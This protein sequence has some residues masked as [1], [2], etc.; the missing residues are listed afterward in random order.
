[1]SI[2][3]R[4]QRAYAK[5]STPVC[6]PVA[7][8]DPSKKSTLFKMDTGFR[9]YDRLASRR[10][11][12]QAGLVAPKSGEGGFTLVELSI[13]IV[14][15]GLIV[16]GVVAGSNMIQSARLKSVIAEFKSYQTAVNMF[17]D[18]YDY[19]PGDLP[20]A[21]SYWPNAGCTNVGFDT[22]ACLNG[23]NGN[24]NGLIQQPS[25]FGEGLRAWQ[26]LALA[27]LIPGT[28]TGSQGSP[29]G[30]YLGINNPESKM[31][32]SGW[33]FRD[34]TV[35]NPSRPASYLELS[36]LTA[37]TLMGA[38]FTPADAMSID[39]KIDDGKPSDGKV[40]GGNTTETCISGTE[41]NLASSKVACL[42]RFYLD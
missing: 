31:K 9:Q 20:T 41:Y 37:G 29:A 8:R 38:T 12:S 3:L 18:K 33:W 14:I 5:Q 15:I 39:S 34:Y 42:M 23:C 21:Y 16:G 19:L 2:I 6:H 4:H 1:L 11:S 13:V 40:L 36:K 28:Y 35:A 26:H 24:G 30:H 25:Y 7:K 32:G 17:R 10:N 27:G 22:D